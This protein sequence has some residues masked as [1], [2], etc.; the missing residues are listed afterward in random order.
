MCRAC[1]K[2]FLV[3]IHAPTQGATQGCSPVDRQRDVSIHA[4]TQGATAHPFLSMHVGACFNPRTHAGC[5]SRAFF[6]IR[7]LMLF[8]STHPRRVRPH[9]F[10]MSSM[11]AGFNPRTHAGC[12]IRFV[13]CCSTR[14]KFQ[15][16]HPRRVRQLEIGTQIRR[17]GFQSTHPR[18]VRPDR[19]PTQVRHVLFQSTHP[20]RVRRH[21][22]AGAVFSTGVSI[23][24]PTQGATSQPKREIHYQRSFNPRT[25]AGCDT[26]RQCTKRNRAVSI[27]AP[28][29]G[30]TYSPVPDHQ[31]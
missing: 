9:P 25:H 15:S 10:T 13:E 8:Q 12:D 14:N 28:T 7:F 16:T 30:A 1:N 27:H 19:N 20:R 3:S 31:S 2:S 29:Q 18:R 23:H 5:D 11:F 17:H 21:H 4:P 24:A 6:A 26:G 22:P